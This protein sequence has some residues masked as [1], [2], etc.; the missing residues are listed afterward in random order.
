MIKIKKDP[1][2]G[3]VEMGTER[4]RHIQEPEARIDGWMWRLGEKEREHRR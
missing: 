4:R 1:E 3:V 2:E